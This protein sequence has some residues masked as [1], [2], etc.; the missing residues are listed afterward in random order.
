MCLRL[1][2]VD[3]GATAVA[4]PLDG[5]LLLVASS[6]RASMSHTH[7]SP[8][9]FGYTFPF[10]T[11]PLS[12]LFTSCLSIQDPR[13]EGG[14]KQNSAVDINLSPPAPLPLPSSS[15]PHA[16]PSSLSLIPSVLVNC[17]I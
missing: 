8:P 13:Q 16:L 14:E 4:A 15:L 9:G 5:F 17:F 6:A 2:G 7:S 11:I 1:T 3:T 10:L 12:S